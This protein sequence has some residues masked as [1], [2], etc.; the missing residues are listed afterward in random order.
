MTEEEMNNLSDEE[1]ERLGNLSIELNQK[2]FEYKKRIAA[3]DKKLKNEIKKLREEL[4][5]LVATS[6][7]GPI[8]EI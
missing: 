6:F 1:I 2:S 4:V 5:S 8:H 3:V 7:I